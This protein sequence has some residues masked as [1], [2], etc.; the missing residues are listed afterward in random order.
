MRLR[1]LAPLLIS[2]FIAARADAEL[3]ADGKKKPK[4]RPAGRPAAGQPHRP[5]AGPKGGA[6]GGAKGASPE[7]LIAR[8][9]GIVLAQPG[10]LFP[11]ERLAQL[12]RERDG[13]LQ[14]LFEDFE[15][16]AADAG[17]PAAWAAKVALA[18]LYKLDGKPAE[19]RR[20]YEAA[21]AE[22]PTDPGA[23]LALADLARERGDRDEAKTQYD[24]ALAHQTSALD[25]EATLRTLRTLMLDDKKV[26]AARAYQRELVKLSGSLAVRGEL[27][28]ELLAR[29]DAAAAEEELREVAKFAQG[30]NRALAT[31]LLEL[32]RTEVAQRK[33]KEAVTTLRRALAAAGGEQGI[34]AEIFA[35]MAEAF[36]ADNDLPELIALLEKEGP[37]DAA[38]LRLLASL[39]EETGELAKAVATYGRALSQGGKHIETRQR[40]IRLLQAQGELDR[41]IAESERLIQAAPK[42]PE[43]VLTLAESLLQR[44]DRKK[45]LEIVERLERASSRD[46]D[47]L[48]RIADFYERL[49]EKDRATQIYT[50]LAGVAPGDPSHW[51]ELGDR[52]WQAGDKKRAVDTWQRIRTAVTPKT[53]ALTA[54]GEVLLDHDLVD[55][56]LAAL[57]EAVDAEPANPRLRRGLALAQERSA[58]GLGSV[59]RIAALE[60]ASRTWQGLLDKA[61]QDR[62]LARE[63]RTHVVTLAALIGRL[64]AMAEPLRLRLMDD[65]PDLEAGKLLVELELKRRRLDLASVAAKRLTDKAPGDEE[66]L[67]LEERVEVAARDLKAAIAT[68]D[69]LAS[70]NPKRA[71][72]Y[73]QRAAQYAAELFEDDLAISYSERAVALSPDDAEG[74]KKLGAMYRRR[75]DFDK[76]IAA[77][78]TAIAKN[79]RLFS[80]YMDLAELLAQRGDLI[81]ADQLW[82]RVVRGSP[83]EELVAQAGRLSLDRN[84]AK[85]TLGEL[86][87]TL[88]PLALS[89]PDKRIYR[90]LLVEAYGRL[91]DPLVTAVRFGTDAERKVAEAELAK[92]G[93]R[94]VKPLLDALSDPA[95]VQ[96]A[97]A[98]D[99]LA[100]VGNRGAGAQLVTFAGGTA[101]EPLRV[102][103]MMAAGT[104]GDP[105]L[106][107]RLEEILLPRGLEGVAPSDPLTVAAGWALA[108]IPD[109]SAVLAMERVLE[110][111]SPE[112]RALAALGLGAAGDAKSRGA[113]SALLLAE[114]ASG[115]ARA[116]AAIALALLGE[117]SRE[118]WLRA[119]ATDSPL[120][121]AAV[122]S[123]LARVGLRDDAERLAAAA[124]ASR[125]VFERDN[126]IEILAGGAPRATLATLRSREDVDV[127]SLVSDLV[128]HAAPPSARVAA[129]ARHRVAIAAALATA[130][131][132]SPLEAERIGDLFAGD[133]LEPVTHGLGPEDA[134]AVE[135]DVAWIRGEVAKVFV[136]LTK[137]QRLELR[138]KALRLLEGVRSDEADA[139]VAAA[140]ADP[141]EPV[142]RAAIAV[143]ARRKGGSALGALA[144]ALAPASAWPRRAS[145]ADALGELG[146]REGGDVEARA[147]TELA[148]ASADDPFSMVRDR[149]LRALARLQHPTARAALVTAKTGERDPELRALAERLAAGEVTP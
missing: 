100:F 40:L 69:R 62:L 111:G 112:I 19:A 45:A 141:S 142:A 129:V 56:A 77:F 38:R 14:K 24:A 36:R 103:A 49:D 140:I 72:E 123:A 32:G 110:R 53:R 146:A 7:A 120:L 116:G 39:Y 121:R 28:R 95:R 114:E 134:R 11:L 79:D 58:A 2:L 107:P 124:M 13:S 147:A 84:A 115:P 90:R 27:G 149:A 109:R 96:I 51:V 89:H 82:R 93:A 35:V 59:G 85:G 126:A 133:G 80:V 68:L 50:R 70:L 86:E 143:A 54:L 20:Q 64:D 18:G 135:P 63:A 106:V 3:S 125:D 87:N 5:A 12:H 74:H 144:E 30:D 105:A 34:K 75:G 15:R 43:F 6:D 71:R 25:K 76:A 47:T 122:V 22:R 4:P 67:L 127:R 101:E 102:R 66:A 60:D 33:R 31:V 91:A 46:E 61:G 119:H 130:A 1:A 21:V 138:L 42:N 37:G 57:R 26:E 17:S 83:D 44:G 98:L 94:G 8:Y 73:L 132:S 78:R 41:A 23:R 113:V 117:K 65:P 139:A 10:V 145:A 99:V 131:K 137:G 29:G 48:G 52:Y 55:E 136:P 9:T 16:R 148:R 97:T 88:L 128:R 92:L 81:G 108:R 118:L 104:L